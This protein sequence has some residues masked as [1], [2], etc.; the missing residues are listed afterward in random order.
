MKIPKE[1][2]D[3]LANRS[4]RDKHTTEIPAEFVEDFY[5]LF[6]ENGYDPVEY[7]AGQFTGGHGHIVFIFKDD[8]YYFDMHE[9]VPIEGRKFPKKY[10]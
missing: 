5:D 7:N 10:L 4:L 8:A 6:I 1:Y 2:L 3:K 9:F